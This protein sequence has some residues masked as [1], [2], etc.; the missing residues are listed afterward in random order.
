MKAL[1]P[2]RR[3]VAR[4]TVGYVTNRASG[5]PPPRLIPD[6]LGPC[7]ALGAA[8]LV[9]IDADGYPTTPPRHS[10]RGATDVVRHLPS[11]HDRPRLRGPRH[12]LLL[13]VGAA[14]WPS[15]LALASS[16]RT[17][18]PTWHHHVAAEDLR[19]L[20][21]LTRP[22]DRVGQAALPPSPS[23][24]TRAAKRSCADNS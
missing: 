16:A 13:R 5:R 6:R 22:A 21:A 17:L 10:M 23:A 11:N 15:R 14:V 7:P 8:S 2:G 4:H 1:L 3:H 9:S 18:R 12:A 24:R 19:W 20:Q